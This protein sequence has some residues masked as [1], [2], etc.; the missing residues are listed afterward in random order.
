[1][2]SDELESQRLQS[3]SYGRIVLAF[4]F[5]LFV[6]AYLFTNFI[7]ALS[8]TAITLYLVYTKLSLRN[9]IKNLDI[10]IERTILEKILF[11]NKPF[12]IVLKIKNNSYIAYLDLEDK[13]PRGCSLHKGTNKYSILMVPGKEYNIKYSIYASERGHYT[14]KG[15]KVTI[16]DKSKLFQYT[17]NWALISTLRVHSDIDSIKKSKA[18]AKIEKL[19]ITAKVGDRAT[20]IRSFELE[21][22]RDYMP[23]DRLKDIEWKA[24]SRLSKL[25]TKVFEEETSI[26]SIILLDCSKSMRK[27][28]GD[29]SKMNH[30]IQLSLQLTKMLTT[31]EH[32]TGLITFDE[33]K[34]LSDIIPSRGRDQFE[35]IFNTL[36]YIPNQIIVNKYDAI[37]PM[38]PLLPKTEPQKR[39]IGMLAPFYTRKKRR[40]TTI[41]QKTGIY[42]AIRTL[43]STSQ[44]SQLLLLITD[45]E[46]N[47][48]SLQEALKLA[49]KYGHKIILIT[50]FTYWYDSYP[51]ELAP[52]LLETI[53]QSYIE[54]QKIIRELRRGLGVKVIEITPQDVGPKVIRELERA[55]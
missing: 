30:S 26:P 12:N 55:R 39:F 31:S 45:I 27:T 52:D 17:M 10:Y 9:I 22:L 49:R 54:K 6:D 11:A 40:Y 19:N 53:Y 35:R 48:Y 2:L 14:F 32:P 42:E 51:T 5:V 4:S 41:T 15:V 50:P 44:R 20:G 36:L 18:M 21:K 37:S 1:M 47:L 29:K 13:I 43:I 3:T 23:G 7:P 28:T 8:A 38:E 46:T 34:V 33:H 25:M 24:T 16:K